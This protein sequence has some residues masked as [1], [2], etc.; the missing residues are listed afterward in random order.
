MA[1][2]R[3]RLT[4]KQVESATTPGMLH[5]GGGLYLQI[6]PA[7]SRS[8]I[9]RWRETEAGVS[10]L[11]S[12]GLGAL[13]SVTLAEA[14]TKADEARRLRSAGLDPLA[15]KKI[16]R[17]QAK[18]AE[19]ELLSD[20][21]GYGPTFGEAADSF[22]EIKKKGLTNEKHARQ[23]ETSLGVTPY[24]ESKVKMSPEAFKAHVTA[25][26]QL[27]ALPM[28]A[29]DT[30][31]VTDVLLPIW[32]EVPETAD[33]V[34]G[35]IE[36]VI[37]ASIA[38]KQHPG[39]NPAKYE[40]HLEHILPKQKVIV[41]H[42][43]AL[44]FADMPAFWQRLTTMRVQSVSSLALGFTIATAARTTETL[45]ARWPEIDG[46]IWTVPPE[47]MKARVPHVVPLNSVALAILERMKAYR[48]KDTDF[49]FPGAKAG[50]P[51][52]PMSLLMVLRRMKLEVTVH[53]F[54]STF[55]DYMAECTDHSPE[56]VE[57]ALAHTIPN[58][59]EAAYRR[60]NLLKKR[61][62]LMADWSC[63]MTSAISAQSG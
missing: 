51:L 49:I 40:D 60:G 35:R 59:V 27:R 50:R 18:A 11:R 25:L 30:K 41:E 1:E 22:V 26:N 52:S 8:W 17:V 37:S 36:S 5:D 62:A 45:K 47:R 32:H 16:E 38:L 28:Q 2:L 55:R 12:M 7:G 9:Y 56:A 48:R 42:H 54:R 33:R 31:A 4:A 39:P 43:A 58:E 19:R 34:R 53:G 6:T 20:L 63:F 44:P 15:Q 10:R 13:S 14:R 46:A 57:M 61:A 23:W 3:N 21:L 29:V 24:D